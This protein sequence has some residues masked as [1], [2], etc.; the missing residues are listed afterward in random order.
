MPIFNATRP[1]PP[2]TSTASGIEIGTI[3]IFRM[4]LATSQMESISHTK[5]GDD[6][7]QYLTGLISIIT[8]G[9]SGRSFVFRSQTTEVR[10]QIPLLGS[11]EDFERASTTIANRLLKTEQET[12]DRMAHMKVE[13]Q[14][15]IVI[16]AMVND[17]GMRRYV[18]C[19]ADHNEF[20]DEK[21]FKKG[22][23][24]PIK[25]RV[26]KAFSC[27]LTE[28]VDV[29]DVMVFDTNP[30]LSKYWWNDFLELDKVHSDEDNTENAFEAIDK[31][32]MNKLKKEHPQDYLPLRNSLVRYF[33]S[34]DS[35]DMN[36]FLDE[37][38]GNYT[39]YDERLDIGA[40]KNVIR[41]LPKKNPKKVFDEKFTIAKERVRA[42]FLN[43]ISL[44]PDIDLKL[45]RDI[46]D[47]ENVVSA[48]QDSDGSKYVRIRSDQGYKYFHER[49]KK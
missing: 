39:P 24:L 42:R 14:K 2:M 25:K 36:E 11:T 23:G 22:K 7:H 21:E 9:S 12:Q 44:T 6:F 4:D 20:L 32:V 37:A 26:Y 41:S 38:I 34:K 15:G 29:S 48:V 3:Q 5:F 19:K 35:F 1:I 8:N 45:H 30:N 27:I 33:R 17:N 43:T 31:G 10:S 47:L 46:P 18:L 28:N 16:Q 40:L 49:A 13:I